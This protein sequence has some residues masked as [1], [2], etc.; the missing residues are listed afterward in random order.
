MI[1]FAAG[2]YLLGRFVDKMGV[3]RPIIAAALMLGSG[4]VLAAYTNDVYTFSMI[5]GVLIGIGTSA[6]FGPLMSDISHW[7]KKHRGIA[8]AVTASG[9][10]LAGAIWSPLI[11]ISLE[12]EGWRFTY[13]AIGVLT[14]STIVPLSLLLRRKA[15]LTEVDSP[16]KAPIVQASDTLVTGIPNRLLILFLM[17]AGLGCCVAMSM[18]QVHIVAYCIDLGYSGTAGATML[19]LMLATGVVSRLISGALAD[20]IGSVQTV[21]LG[22]ALQCTA[23][24][25]YLPFDGLVSLYIVS[26][27]F[28]LSQG[29]IVPGYAMIVRDYLPAKEAGEKVGLVLM[30]TILGMAL[31]GWLSGWIYDLTQSYEAAFIHGIA[32]NMANIL[33]L[34]MILLR[35]RRS[36]PIT[37]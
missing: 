26:A 29:G 16:T 1:G 35:T 25:L 14:V 9:N 34:L 31:G 2:N 17:L 5:Q 32:W 3:V 37:A 8:V 23:L 33:I 36:G 19:S 10:Y 27:I 18:P 28:G 7:F 11:Q 13:I 22:S 15:N 30:M 12:A 4:S 6:T 21:L 20:R 24:F